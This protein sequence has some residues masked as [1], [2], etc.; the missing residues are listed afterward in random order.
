M[1]SQ[2]RLPRRSFESA[3]ASEADVRRGDRRKANVRLNGQWARNF[4]TYSMMIMRASRSRN[5]LY[6][7]G[8]EDAA[9]ACHFQAVEIPV[10]TTGEMRDVR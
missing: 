5:S 8:L 10:A 1:R 4:F 6:C 3:P 9:L 7:K 2:S